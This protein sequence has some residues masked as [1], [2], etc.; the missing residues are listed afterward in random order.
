MTTTSLTALQTLR[1][2]MD[3]KAKGVTAQMHLSFTRLLSAYTGD[4]QWYTLHAERWLPS[5]ASASQQNQKHELA[6]V[7]E[8]EDDGDSGR[9]QHLVIGEGVQGSASGLLLGRALEKVQQ[10]LPPLICSS[11]TVKEASWHRSQCTYQTTVCLLPMQRHN[12]GSVV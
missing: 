11:L 12:L 2:I 8:Q 10:I 4:T 1:Y 5:D 7:I 6:A 3:I 9:R